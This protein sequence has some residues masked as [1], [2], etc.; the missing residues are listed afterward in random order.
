MCKPG[1]PRKSK[2]SKLG[3]LCRGIVPKNLENYKLWVGNT[4]SYLTKD[5]YVLYH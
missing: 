2:L 3:S 1:L 5:L 4:N